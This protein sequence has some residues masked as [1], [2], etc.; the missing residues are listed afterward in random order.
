MRRHLRFGLALAW[1]VLLAAAA[2]VASVYAGDAAKNVLLISWDGCDR[3]VF[4]E[5]LDQGK[6]PHAAAIIQEGSWQEIEVTGHATCTKPGHAQLL[7]GLDVTTLGISSN[8]E[9]QAIPA[10]YTIFERVQKQFGAAGKIRTFMVV[11]KINN[12]GGRSAE[13]IQAAAVA[14][15]KTLGSGEKDEP[16]HLTK[17][18]LDAFDAVTRDAA[19]NGPACLAHLERF[20]E[21]RFLG[22]FHFSDPDRAGHQFG[23]A[24]PEY[25]QQ[26]IA[27][28][29]W[30]GRIA[31]W[32]KQNDL[33][34]KTLIYVTCDHGF[35]PNAKSH[36]NAP[37]IWL[38]TNDRGVVHGGIQADVPAT[39]LER[40]GID[41][42]KLEPKLIGKPLLQDATAQ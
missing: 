24:S 7:T 5:L 23:S 4:K 35:D 2:P 8:T 17:S 3:S 14:A 26:I 33:Y 41:L 13:E 34:E 30:L 12:L 9:Y 6:L 36:S 25:R 40:F 10:G 22:F 20:K 37:H 32:L 42:D 27:C 1:V 21:Q 39:I 18:K 11:A 29:E 19:A 31:A 38:V 16:Y 28:D 15:G